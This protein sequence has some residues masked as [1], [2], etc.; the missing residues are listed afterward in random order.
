MSVSPQR[1]ATVGMMSSRQSADWTSLSQT[2]IMA[3]QIG[4][5]FRIRCAAGPREVE[6]R[7]EQL[8]DGFGVQQVVTA[9]AGDQLAGGPID[10]GDALHDIV[11]GS[12]RDAGRGSLRRDETSRAA[13]SPVGRQSIGRRR[14]SQGRLRRTT[15]AARSATREPPVATTPGRPVPPLLGQVGST[16]RAARP[17]VRPLPP[18][19]QRPQSV[20]RPDPPAVA[21]RDVDSTAAPGPPIGDFAGWDRLP[22]G[23]GGR[24]YDS[25]S[26]PH[27]AHR[28]T[29][30][31][32][33]AVAVR[34]R[35]VGLMSLC[36][37]K[38][39]CRI[40]LRR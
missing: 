22:P 19:G 18:A 23:C 25:F 20:R 37:G 1:S 2:S 6:G 17:R 34:T 8:A 29:D 16:G 33:D 5:Q 12:F 14:G 4:D 24:H 3:P 9:L 26:V 30:L 36:A 13:R 28:Q 27:I 39:D 11:P 7:S 38:G 31:V 32:R 10:N 15:Q 40:R 35:A 21:G